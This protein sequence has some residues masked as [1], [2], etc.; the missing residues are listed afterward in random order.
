MRV[1][2]TIRTDT[3]L[4]LLQQFL[5]RQTTVLKHKH[6]PLSHV[7]STAEHEVGNRGNRDGGGLTFRIAAF[8]SVVDCGC[9]SRLA[10]PTTRPDNGDEDVEISE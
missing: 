6:H 7:S 5:H 1:D 9:R 3:I 8:L 2:M 10:I 4:R